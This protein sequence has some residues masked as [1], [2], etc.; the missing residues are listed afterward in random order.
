MQ[1]TKH[2]NQGGTY[3][4]YYICWDTRQ[5]HELWTTKECEIPIVRNIV[6]GI[7]FGWILKSPE[8][9][10]ESDARAIKEQGEKDV[11]TNETWS[12]RMEDVR[13][14]RFK[15]GDRM[16]RFT[17]IQNGCEWRLLCLT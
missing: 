13:G 5:A 4:R 2:A 6:P 9:I 17:E 1:I 15:F 16:Y 14:R 8:P 7:H 11:E 3:Y 12:S 10:D